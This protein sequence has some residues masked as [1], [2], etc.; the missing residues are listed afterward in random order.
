MAVEVDPD[1]VKILR[2]NVQE[3]N[4]DIVQR[5]LWSS[6]SY[7][8]IDRSAEKSYAFRVLEVPEGTLDALPDLTITDLLERFG[9]AKVDL[10]KLDIEGAEETLFSANYDEWIDRIW[11]LIVEVNGAEAYE[12]V[13]GVMANRGFSMQRQGRS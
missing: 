12:A 13:R 3:Y 11:G 7:C 1:N 5:T 10:L 6:H 8:C 9:T 2:E 4:F